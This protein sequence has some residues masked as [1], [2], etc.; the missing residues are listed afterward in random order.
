M[1]LRVLAAALFVCATGAAQAQPMD[2]FTAGGWRG[3]AFFKSAQFSHCAIVSDQGR[4]KFLFSID[5]QNR[6]NFGLGQKALNFTKGE[7]LQGV[8]QIGD[9]PAA[10][11]TFVAA[12]TKLAGTPITSPEEIKRLQQR[13]RGKIKLGDFALE[14][15]L[16]GPD[17]FAKLSACVA[18]R[19]G[20]HEV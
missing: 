6:V 2:A 17:A 15:E 16:P 14:F 20:A 7:K 11:R 4:W 5:R 12:R 13:G 1:R 18:K 10:T 9:A 3:G 8:L 19:T